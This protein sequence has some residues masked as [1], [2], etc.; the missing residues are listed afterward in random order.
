MQCGL[1]LSIRSTGN[2]INVWNRTANAVA[3][4]RDMEQYMK[5]MLHCDELSYVCAPHSLNRRHA[6]CGMQS[7]A[8]EAI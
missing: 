7:T 4:N 1:V 8:C 5:D 6:V 3:E 2:L